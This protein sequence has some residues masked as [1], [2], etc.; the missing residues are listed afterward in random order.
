MKNLIEAVLNTMDECQG[1]EKSLEVGAGRS[2]YKGVAD[3][4]V[5]L[6]VGA[7]MRKNGLII[8]P[9]DVTPVYELSSWEQEYQ[10]KVSRKQSIF[11]QVTTKYLLCHKSGETVELAGAG[12]GVDSQDKATGK[13]TT[14]AL[15]YTLLYTFLVATGH[16]DDTDNTHSDELEKPMP[17]KELKDVTKVKAKQIK[18]AI[19]SGKVEKDIDKVNAIL[20]KG[21]FKS[22]PLDKFNKLMEE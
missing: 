21:G 16:I 12:S 14:Y 3:K 11:T 15:K 17:K 6:K 7:A 18:E 5:K 19:D 8:L 10:G 1:I 22:L 13:A 2:S 4:D 20:N 9:T